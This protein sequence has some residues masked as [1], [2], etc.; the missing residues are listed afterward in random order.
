[1]YLVVLK[2]SLFIPLFRISNLH[3]KYNI[4]PG[5]TQ[6]INLEI[7]EN[8]ELFLNLFCKRKRIKIAE[9]APK[10]TEYFL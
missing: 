4:L 9:N 2:V 7:F 1:M 5:N 10:V 3:I 8:I 6:P